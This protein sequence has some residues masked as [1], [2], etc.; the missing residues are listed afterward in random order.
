MIRVG[1][2]FQRRDAGALGAL[3]DRVRLGEIPGDVGTYASA[4]VSALTGEPLI[5]YCNAPEEAQVLADLYVA[6]GVTRPAVE[7]LT[8]LRP[9]K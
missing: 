1:L 4:E 5:V 9:A 3:A 6:V 8:G 7:E 2:R